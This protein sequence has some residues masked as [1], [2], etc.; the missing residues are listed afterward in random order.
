MRMVQHEQ[1]DRQLE[2][3]LESPVVQLLVDKLL[4]GSPVRQDLD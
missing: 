4:L 2:I 3:Q 1:G